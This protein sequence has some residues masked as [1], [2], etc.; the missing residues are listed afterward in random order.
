MKR[1]K[2]SGALPSLDGGNVQSQD[3]HLGNPGSRFSGRVFPLHSIQ[4]DSFFQI[5]HPCVLQRDRAMMLFYS[6]MEMLWGTVLCS[7][8]YSPALRSL[9]APNDEECVLRAEASWRQAASSVAQ[10]R[11]A[12]HSFNRNLHSRQQGWRVS[13]CGLSPVG[14]TASYHRPLR[15]PDGGSKESEE[16]RTRTPRRCAGRVSCW[17]FVSHNDTDDAHRH[18]RIS[19]MLA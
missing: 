2:T 12:Y 8:A 1:E 17:A 15:K 6:N 16:T 18:A 3:V 11:E 4:A 13:K 9:T 14:R 5:E 10:S 19:D 7:V